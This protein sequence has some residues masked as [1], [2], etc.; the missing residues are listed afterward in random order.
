MGSVALANVDGPVRWTA[1]HEPG[2]IDVLNFNGM[3]F[4]IDVILSGN[5]RCQDGV[6]PAIFDC[7]SA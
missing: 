6:E 5:T 3:R 2:G 1:V 7:F 4:P